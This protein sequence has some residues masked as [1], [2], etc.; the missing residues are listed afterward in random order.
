MVPTEEELKNVIETYSDM[1]LKLSLSYVRDYDVAE[2][3][4]QT[5]FV[6][7]MTE[8]K[9]FESEEHKKSWLLRVAINE[10][11]KH[12]RSYWYAKRSEFPSEEHLTAKN[13][14]EHSEV[15]EAVYSLPMKYREVI[16]LYY[17]EE[18]R[19]KEISEVLKRKENTV[20]SD[21]YRARKL[22]KKALEETYG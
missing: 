4:T 1:I 7:Y 16:H 15:L 12:F 20:M 8:K 18:L 17:Y 11:K 3:I 14:E 2:D 5:V 21:L 10:C 9:V 22:L 19:V 6:K 13:E